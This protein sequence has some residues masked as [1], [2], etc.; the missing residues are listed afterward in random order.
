[1]ILVDT[2]IWIEHLRVGCPELSDLLEAGEV[3]AHPF[4][5]GELA[6]CNLSNRDDVL[7][8]LGGMPETRVASHQEVLFFVEQKRLMG[9]VIGYV[10]VHLLAAAAL[11][12]PTRIWTADRRL[13]QAAATLDLAH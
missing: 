5:V 8:V 7:S 1:M 2:S 11:T 12:P 3:L 10:D 4:V 6:C 13:A 9:R